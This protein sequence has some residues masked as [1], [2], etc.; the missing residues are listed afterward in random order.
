[1]LEL[2]GLCEPRGASLELD[3][4]REEPSLMS[5]RLREAFEGLCEA[6]CQ[7]GPLVL[8]LEDLHWGDLS[9][10]KLVESALLALAERPLLVIAT[11]RPEL[12]EV[13]P[14][15]FAAAA[16]CE[17]RV[18]RLSPRAAESLVRALLPDADAPL[19]ARLVERADGHALWLEEL[20]RAVVER[21]GDEL[22][23]T[24]LAMVQARAQALPPLERRA[25][26]AASVF[27]RRSWDAAVATLLG[28]D[29]ELAGGLLSK[30]VGRDWLTADTGSRF[31][32]TRQFSFRQDVAREGRLRH[33]HRGGPRAWAPPRRGLARA[34]RRARG[35]GARAPLRARRR[36]REGGRGLRARR[37]R[38]ARLERSGRRHRA[39]RARLHG[40]R[41]PRAPRPGARGASRGAPPAWGDRAR[42]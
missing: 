40:E 8:V 5:E 33:A 7:R 22:P 20:A 1:V 15:I 18:G 28:C 2:V 30:L 6:R 42:S 16:P 38:R 29:A 31:A 26:R 11:G 21:A 9:S 12:D 17:V 3:R 39:R 10:V 32:P 41:G 27:G 19:V 24:V 35:R 23:D 34:R 25:L 37:A 36:A 4:A 13:F 14:S